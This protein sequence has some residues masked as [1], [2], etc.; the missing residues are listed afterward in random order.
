MDKGKLM[1]LVTFILA[2]IFSSI[3][4]CADSTA[5]SVPFFGATM[6]S[7]G[8]LTGRLWA[9]RRSGSTGHTI[10]SLVLL[11]LGF[12]ASALFLVKDMTWREVVI[13]CWLT[14]LP[15]TLGILGYM[16]FCRERKV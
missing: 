7:A 10:P 14:V 9:G 1:T 15:V 16:V 8:I 6:L 4:A 11:N 2:F 3:T 5:S 13:T 12:F